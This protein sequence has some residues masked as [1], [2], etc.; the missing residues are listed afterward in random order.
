M[1]FLSD[2]SLTIVLLILF[3]ASWAGQAIFQYRTEL[4]ESELHGQ[5][6]STEEYVDS[7]LASTFENWQSEFLQL[8]TMVVLTSFLMHKGSPESKDSEQK[9][10]TKLN[11]ILGILRNEKREQQKS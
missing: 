11:L 8:G 1:K 4:S 10:E 7:F 2:Y 5:K 3:L 6:L 9:T